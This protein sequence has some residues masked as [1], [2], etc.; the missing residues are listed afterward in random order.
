MGVDRIT[1]TCRFDGFLY[2]SFVFLFSNVFAILMFVVII[3]ISLVRILKCV[4]SFSTASNS[5]N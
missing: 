2:L 5:F 3:F 4:C 1:V